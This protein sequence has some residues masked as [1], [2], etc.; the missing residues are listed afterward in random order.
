MESRRRSAGANHGAAFGVVPPVH[1]RLLHQD[2]EL[3]PIPAVAAS[4]LQL[5]GRDTVGAAEI[6]ETIGADGVIAAEVL[7]AANS[8][9]YGIRGE[10]V[11]LLHATRL[12][13]LARIRALA[14]AIGL[15]RYLG[16]TLQHPA[17]RRCFTHNLACA[18]LGEQIAVRL[19]GS[20][21]D[22]YSAGLLHDIGRLALVVAH[23][24]TYPRLLDGMRGSGPAALAVERAA[25]GLDHCEAG[26][27]VA[28]QLILPQVFQDVARHHHDPDAVGPGDALVRT[29]VACRLA[30][31]MGCWVIAPIATPDEARRTEALDELTAPLPAAA[32]FTLLGAC[33]DI[34]DT[35]RAQ[36]AELETALDT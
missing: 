36:L 23:P 5:V 22:A 15:R 19:G 29:G 7:R 18:L 3:P 2:L 33:D 31:W 11:N 13:G 10:V 26:A 30:D 35:V 12:L 25:F 24:E 14:A 34:V 21:A 4:L 1:S 20:T 6:A 27:W 8:A 32:R 17:V 28:A 9:H 16:P